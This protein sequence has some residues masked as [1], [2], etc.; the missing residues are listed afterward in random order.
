MVLRLPLPRETYS[1][2]SKCL[3]FILKRGISPLGMF[4]ENISLRRND[5]KYKE[6]GV[7][8]KS[9]GF[10]CWVLWMSWDAGVPKSELVKDRVQRAQSVAWLRY[11][12][13]SRTRWAQGRIVRG[14]TWLGRTRR[15]WSN[16]DN[17]SPSPQHWRMECEIY[18][19]KLV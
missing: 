2:I 17:G 9:K 13:Q 8:Y 15:Q 7:Y 11:Q 4:Q 5:M 19:K 12:N 14:G 3:N 1:Q 6:A 18:N 10:N 16:K